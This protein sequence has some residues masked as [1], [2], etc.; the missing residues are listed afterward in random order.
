MKSNISSDSNGMK[1]NMYN[2]Y[3]PVFT[4]LCCEQVTFQ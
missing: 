1:S 2:N 3:Y 4:S